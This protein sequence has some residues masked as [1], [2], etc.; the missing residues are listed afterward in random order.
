MAAGSVKA[1]IEYRGGADIYARDLKRIYKV[2]LQQGALFWHGRYLKR[3]FTAAAYSL[4]P[5]VYK[6]RTYGYMLQKRGFKRPGYGKFGSGRMARD[7]AFSR[8]VRDDRPLVHTGELRRR[9]LRKARVTGT[10]KRATVHLDVPAYVVRK[11]WADRPQSEEEKARFYR[12]L[13]PHLSERQIRRKVAL[14]RRYGRRP[15]Q[16]PDMYAELT[17]VNPREMKRI[18]AFIER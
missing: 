14:A 3:H 4:Y 1:S 13:Y 6:G 11:P 8:R 12:R 7:I 18:A 17:A 10:S 15:R 2:C 9:A 16:R 5:G